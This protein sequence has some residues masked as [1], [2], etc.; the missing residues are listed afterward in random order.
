VVAVV[1]VGRQAAQVLTEQ[2]A[3]APHKAQQQEQPHN[4]H[5]QILVLVLMQDFQV[6]QAEIE[7]EVRRSQMQLRVQVNIL[8]VVVVEQE[9]QAAT[10]AKLPPEILQ[11]MALQDEKVVTE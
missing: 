4:L 1:E 8:V 7:L 5:N 9:L 6:Q 10:Q 2:A 3:A 11:Q